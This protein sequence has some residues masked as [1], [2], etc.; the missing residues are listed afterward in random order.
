[1]RKLIEKLSII[2]LCATLVVSNNAMSLY[3][4]ES[5]D[6]Q[7]GE[8]EELIDEQNA[9]IEFSE[10][11]DEYSFETST[12]RDEEIESSSESEI[13]ESNAF[14][15]ESDEE[16]KLSE[17][18]Y[19]ITYT[20]QKY[21]TVATV[22]GY[23]GIASGDLIIPEYLDNVYVVRNIA[24]GAFK[25]CKGFTGNLVLPNTLQTI[26]KNAFFGCS[27]FTGNLK[28]PDSVTTIGDS[29]FHGCRGFNGTL[30]L[31]RR[32][33][34]IGQDAF[35]FCEKLNGTI[36]IPDSVVSISDY[37][38]Y[39]CSN[40]TA[41][42]IGKSV[43][44]IGAL[45]F[46]S[47]SG[48]KG[49]LTIPNSVKSIGLSAFSYCKFAGK[50]IIPSS[51]TSI[52]GSIFVGNDF[53]CIVN[54]SSA[55]LSLSND[56]YWYNR[57]TN[58]RVTSITSGVVVKG[59]SSGITQ[60][61]GG[62]ATCISRAICSHC[63]LEYGDLNPKV[64]EGDIEVKNAL[65]AK[66]YREGYTGDKYCLSCY[67]KIADGQ[68]LS[69]TRHT[70]SVAIKEN[71]ISSTCLTEG[72]YENVVYCKIEECGA[73]ISRQVI[74]TKA[75][76]HTPSATVKENI[77]PST[78]L[79]EGSYENVVYCKVEECK[80]EI[81][82]EII[83]TKALGHI[84]DN[85]DDSC[86]RCGEDYYANGFWIKYI[87]D[88]TYTGKAITPAIEVY[89]G[90][91]LLSPNVDY[92]VR[93]A[94][95]TNASSDKKATVT[96]TGKGNYSKTETVDFTINPRSIDEDTFSAEDI[97]LVVTKTIQKPKPI[98]MWNGKV[99]APTNYKYEYYMLDES[100]NKIG[101]ALSSVKDAGDYIIVISGNEKN[102]TGSREIK[103]TLTSEKKLASKL[104][105]TKIANQTYTGEE[106]KPVLIVKD[107]KNP[108]TLEDDY[109]VEYENNI[110]VGTATVIITGNGNYIGTKR[111]N[112]NITGTPITKS[113][114]DN[115][116]KTVLYKGN[117]YTVEDF[118]NVKLYIKAT[119][120]TD[121]IDLTEGTDYTVSYLNNKKVGTATVVFTGIN[122]YTGELK[123]TFKITQF[124]SA[125]DTE[126][127]ISVNI[128]PSIEYSKGGAK[129][130]VTVTYKNADGTTDTLVEK[131]DYTLAYTN[132]TAVNDGSNENKLP[133]VKVTFKGN[134][135][136]TLSANY[137]ITPKDI[138][139]TEA[140]APDK[141]YANKSGAYKSVVTVTDK[142]G[143]KLA[144]NKDYNAIVT[145]RIK[146]ASEDLDAKAIVDADTIIVATITAKDG[147]NYTG[148]TTCEYRI[149]KAAISPANVKF[150]SQTY[151][152]KTIELDPEK[153][154]ISA[155]IGTKTN[156]VYGEDY[157][158]VPG[159]YTNNI[160]K[161]TASVMIRGINSYG[162][163][164]KVNFT[165]KV[166]DFRWWWR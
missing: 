8:S 109:I 60:C 56:E 89:D 48:L 22:T 30:S 146:D 127:R 50:V 139:K 87:E 3:A 19:T 148:T 83:S 23:T 138:S 135:N 78:C 72:S 45:A 70:P 160:K 105:V 39:N 143:K 122:G 1:M 57:S 91:N 132:N 47:C 84:D 145:Y 17:S 42:L 67:E 28:I 88:Q 16:I 86:D 25:D 119:A 110:D 12:E 94:N 7:T 20:V 64:H 27:G 98:L 93:F 103:L 2:V 77:V 74:K 142:D 36:I 125:E 51:V 4:C 76:G 158:I 108:L 46:A 52:G 41:L 136:G 155:K 21:S 38:F 68:V 112:F 55:A 151:T 157:E 118:E 162:G 141:V 62:K 116:P 121:R 106:I 95:N 24:E 113:T 131:T 5:Q 35:G 104:T 66:C 13:I 18:T 159:S 133:T 128:V 63:G 107:G 11:T 161:G 82:R 26:G 80:T 81:S 14:E 96:I 123:K 129:P 37:A 117:D 73:E 134:Y 61:Y 54:N 126:G 31:G 15:M 97:A 32:V 49:T 79:T 156:L 140:T 69:K 99:L 150:E 130:E 33:T 100:G 10:E 58:E 101:E 164:K 111:V 34:Q 102:F 154:I 90:K 92:S 166:K 115:I 71:I 65:S 149:S 137:V 163:T 165:I 53:T 75:L 59:T 152:G 153:D 9:S 147:G 29:A 85:H 144:A 120:K 43:E 114:A 6:E 124:K 44:S 40:N